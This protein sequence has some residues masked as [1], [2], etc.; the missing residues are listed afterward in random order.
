[1]R[2][3]QKDS[4]YRYNSDTL[5][6]YDFIASFSPKGVMLDVGCGCGILGLLLKRDFPILSLKLLDIQDDNCKIAHANAVQNELCVDE[7]IHGDF[8]KT[9]FESK[10]DWIISNPPFYHHGGMKSEADSL[11]LSRHSSALPFDAFA[12]KVTKTRSNRGYFCFCYDAKQ[13]THL[14]ASLMKHGLNVEDIC[15]VHPKMNKEASLV[16]IRARKN[17]KAL[18]KVH[19]PLFIYDTEAF[20]QRVQAIFTKSQ[21]KSLSWKN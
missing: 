21:T 18:C 17:S 13:L 19:E 1:M 4:G 6:L 8:L 9:S 12:Q 3:F 14:L 11:R 16:M 15:F 7:M 2:L 20:S 10:C 5:L